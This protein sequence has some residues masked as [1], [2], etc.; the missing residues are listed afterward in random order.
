LFRKKVWRYVPY[1]VSY[2]MVMDKDDVVEKKKYFIEL[3][4]SEDYKIRLDAWE[5]VPGLLDCGVIEKDDFLDKKKYL[6]DLLS[7]KD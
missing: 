6:F 4:S 7:L 1:V 5:F 3:L 2:C